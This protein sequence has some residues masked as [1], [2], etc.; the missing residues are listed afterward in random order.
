MS[1]ASTSGRLPTLTLNRRE[2]RRLRRG[3]LWVFS[4]EVDNQNSPLKGF[5][6]GD[7]VTVMT[8]GGTPLGSAYVNPHALICARIYSRRPNVRLDEVLITHRLTEALAL[9]SALYPTPH[10]RLCYGEADGLP[11]L[12]V[13]RYGDVLI[14]QITTAGMDLCRGTI[15]DALDGLLSPV[16]IVMR[17]DTAA[18]QLEGLEQG[19][20]TVRG[21]LPE[22]LLIEE[23]GVQFA[24]PSSG[25]QKTGWFYDQRSNR[26]SFIRHVAGKRVLDLFSYVGAWGIRA[27]VAGAESVVCVDSS[28]PALA[29]LAANAEAN[30]VG[31]TVATGRSD[32]FEALRSLR[33]DGDRFDVVVVDPPALI[34]RRKDHRAGLEAYRRLNRL[35]MKVLSPG[36]ILVSCSCSFHLSRDDL[37][38]A[39][40]RAALQAGAEL[41]II[42]QGHAGADHPVHPAIP[43]SDYLKSYTARVLQA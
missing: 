12:V 22:Q 3:H 10:Y 35:A 27:A 14:V 1:E 43:E 11:G 20:E 42:E 15:I 26:D 30:G 38:G 16:A 36:G 37:R 9:R 13:D 2:E 40:E 5:T 34:K 32:V 6:A 18:R 41:Q 31:G 17:D 29:T 4:N 21:T 28:A 19:V 24:V 7:E 25:G 33:D 23:S 39:M 8:H